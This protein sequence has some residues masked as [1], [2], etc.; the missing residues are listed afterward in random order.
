MTTPTAPASCPNC[1]NPD[2]EKT[3]VEWLK[4]HPQ[5]CRPETPAMKAAYLAAW[6]EARRQ[7][8]ALLKKYGRHLPECALWPSENLAATLS[9]DTTPLVCTCGLADALRGGAK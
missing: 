4:R 9:I 3:Y 7:E 1:P 8:R 2:A 6:T 5:H